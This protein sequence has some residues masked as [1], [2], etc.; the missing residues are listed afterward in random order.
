[1]ESEPSTTLQLNSTAHMIDAMESE[2]PNEERLAQFLELTTAEAFEFAFEKWYKFRC[3]AQQCFDTLS[4]A[5]LLISNCLYHIVIFYKLDP[6]Q[7]FKTR[8]RRSYFEL[9][10]KATQV[11]TV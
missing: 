9:L 8:K 4:R 3:E 7:Y 10:Y 5:K 6:D 1:M 11:W 2:S